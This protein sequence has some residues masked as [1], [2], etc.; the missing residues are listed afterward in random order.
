VSVCLALVCLIL[1]FIFW[2]SEMVRE[3]EGVIYGTQGY[4]SF[5]MAAVTPTI[6]FKVNST[7]F[8]ICCFP[9]YFEIFGFDDN[10]VFVYELLEECLE[11]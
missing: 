7:G 5:T 3:V 9:L 11:Y 10:L 6:A 2:F 8:N 4:R 1:F